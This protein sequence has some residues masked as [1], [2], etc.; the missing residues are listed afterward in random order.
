MYRSPKPHPGY[1]GKA[2]RC[3]Q[4]AA[5]A[6]WQDRS[7]FYVQG[8][9]QGR[10]NELIPHAWCTDRDGRLIE[11]TWDIRNATGAEVYI[12]VAFSRDQ[13]VH[14]QSH[15]G[16]YGWYDGFAAVLT[17]TTVESRA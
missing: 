16:R 7:L 10:G 11:V 3:W 2:G 8:L 12:G 17:T 14:L 6:L 4:N 13:L 5:G 1:Q 15:F 9:V